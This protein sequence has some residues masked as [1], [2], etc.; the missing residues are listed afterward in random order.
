MAGDALRIM[1]V[2]HRF[3]PDAV[4]GV[5]RYTEA[6][7]A[8]LT[9]GG[10]AV[11]VVT[12][13]PGWEPR[14]ALRR[15]RLADGTAVY[16]L[17]GGDSP[18]ERPL[19]HHD[20][21]ERLFELVLAESAPDVVHFN[22]L[23]DLSPR[24][25]EIALRLRAAVVLSLHDFFF[26]CPRVTLQTRSGDQCAGPDAG[27]ACARTCFA[28]APA[29]GG[30]ALGL[31][32]MYFR[33]LLDLPQFVLCPSR[34]VA[35]YF[36]RYGADPARLRVVPNG[37]WVPP[38]APGEP[39]PPTPR[40]RGRLNLGFFGSV[41]PHK[42]VHVI[43]K[44]LAEARLGQAAGVD[45]CLD[46]HGPIGDGQ[47]AAELKA[48]AAEVPRLRLELHG[49]YEPGRLPDLLR[50]VDCVVAPSQW[51]ETFL[52]VA[53]EALA[54]GVPIAVSRLGAMPDAVAE[55]VNGFTFEHN[56]PDQLAA[57]LRRLVDDES[58]VRRLREG[59]RASYVPGLDEHAGV[60]RGLYEQAVRDL[61][62][63]SADPPRAGADEL[64]FLHSA[65]AGAE[66]AF[67]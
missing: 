58:L 11:A 56:C 6:L 2:S 22:H 35:D 36:E 10:D 64:G 7:A 32:A 38:V 53:R 37:I 60:I 8:R 41:V 4:A 66:A 39:P 61:A 47:Y 29:P 5:E 48:R 24:F 57:V 55:G 15:E 33:R 27:R 42:G 43:V 63:V 17:A 31:R 46:V 30:L 20:R 18:R 9:A 50:D 40:R 23:A 62:R 12:R 3:P 49:P 59:A 13:Q 44:A 54:R 67:A 52:L 51:P 45:V 19:A 28:D 65:L 1:L 25:L 26:A 34:Y 14:P 16:R 21:L